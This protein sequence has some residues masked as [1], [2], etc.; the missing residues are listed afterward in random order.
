MAFQLEVNQQ[1]VLG[2]V[3]Y[4]VAEHPVARDMPYGQEGRQAIVYKLIA[5]DHNM[6]LKVLKPRF[7]VPGMVGLSRRL[8]SFANLPGL[9]VCQRTVLNPQTYSAVLRE[10]PDLLYGVLM[11]WVEGPTWME[12]VQNK[13][14]VTPEQ[15]LALARSLAGVMS[16]ME[17]EGL[18]HCDLSGPNILLPMLAPSFASESGMSAAGAA[19]A[20]V[21]VEQMFGPDL[22]KPELVP[23]GSPGYAHKIAPDGMWESDAD[24]LSGAVLL[25]EMLAWCDEQVR[26]VAWGE[27]YFEPE[28]MQKDSEHYHVLAKALWERWGDSVARLFDQAW[29]SDTLADCP[30]FGEWLVALPE[31]VPATRA[32]K[33]PSTPGEADKPEANQS[34]GT[35]ESTH[36]RGAINRAPI[37]PALREL[38]E[39]ARN[40]DAHND[41][42]GALDSYRKAHALAPEGSGLAWELALIVRDLETRLGTSPASAI[43]TA[44]PEA[45]DV[46]TPLPVDE[47]VATPLP[48][49]GTAVSSGAE[50]TAQEQ[51]PPSAPPALDSDLASLLARLDIGAQAAPSDTA[52]DESATTVQA[53]E[54]MPAMSE[55]QDRHTDSEVYQLMGQAH[56]L[57]ERGDIPSALESYRKALALAQTGSGLAQELELIVSELESKQ[58]EPGAVIETPAPEQEA[59]YYEPDPLVTPPADTSDAT[60]QPEQEPIVT[61]TDDLPEQEVESAPPPPVEDNQ[62]MVLKL[63]SQARSMEAG[64]DL[65]GALDT[66][67]KAMELAAV[68]SAA[69]EALTPLV[70]RLEKV[71]AESSEPEQSTAPP[72]IRK[73]EPATT[74]ITEIP[75]AAPPPSPPSQPPPITPATPM[76]GA[77]SAQAVEKPGIASTPVEKV[78]RPPADAAKT[79]SRQRLAIIGGAVAAVLLIVVAIIILMPHGGDTGGGG[80]ITY[81]ASTSTNAV[82]IAGTTRVPINDLD[83]SVVTT[84]LPFPVSFYG[85]TFTGVIT[86]ST[87]GNLQF[88]SSN[89]VTSH[90]CNSALPWK[91][92]EEFSYVMMP[93]WTDLTMN[94]DDCKSGSEGC[95]IFTSVSGDPGKRIFNIEWR[96][97]L[98]PTQKD[99]KK[100]PA[101]FE[102]RLH[103]NQHEFD[104]IYGKDMASQGELATVGV[105]QDVSTGIATL[106]SCNAPKLAPGMQITFKEV[107]RNP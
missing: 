5:D 101:H 85:I 34:S 73:P 60:T 37:D 11:P 79:K 98:G 78:A 55:T 22:K 64:G 41:V 12:V 40:F 68:G 90:K 39:Q 27:S 50:D 100:R 96:A 6:A 43:P 17:Q 33:V 87:N 29:G 44:Q 56:A 106:F 26:N 66:Y 3:T 86:V 88:N 57:R 2:G 75:Q 1:I 51:V 82:F 84:T 23:G 46:T 91:D 58:D 14:V 105:Q 54:A 99:P 8:A 20:L 24:R 49:D 15:S 80:N 18:A 95:G 65:P 70:A 35:V 102:I 76:S 31:S 72:P 10:F 7:R 59:P 81:T 61:S 38:M 107:I 92:K 42:A 83:D 74:G 47:T 45:V 21:D 36:S 94:P 104:F 48:V 16:A 4:H 53:P 97:D 13:E 69:Y 67:R 19:V 62:G 30:T 93:L 9:Q 77:V 71:Q 28:E 25:A 89:I 63:A 52:T 32:S 103:E